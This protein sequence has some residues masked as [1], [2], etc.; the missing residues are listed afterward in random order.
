MI[1]TENAKVKEYLENFCRCK[2][3]SVED[4]CKLKIV[5]IVCEYIQEREGVK[6]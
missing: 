4:A 2:H 3:L 1:D 5:Q 6:A